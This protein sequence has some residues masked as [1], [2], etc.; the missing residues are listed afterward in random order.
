MMPIPTVRKAT[1]LI[2]TL[3]LTKAK[4]FW[5]EDA[6]WLALVSFRTQQIFLR[7]WRALT[8]AP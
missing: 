2:G 4:G 3:F 1:N 6:D 5:P 8:D 7:G